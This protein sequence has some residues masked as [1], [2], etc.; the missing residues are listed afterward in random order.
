VLSRRDDSDDPDG[1][2]DTTADRGLP[3]GVGHWLY[4]DD[5]DNDGDLDLLDLQTGEWYVNQG[6][7]RFAQGANCIYQQTMPKRWDPDCEVILVDLDN[8][9][10]RDLVMAADHNSTR[11]AFLNLGDG[12]YQEI[13]S[14]YGWNRRQRK[15]GDVDGDGDLDMLA[16]TMH[17]RIALYRNDT[18]EHGL[19]LKLVP[20][21]AAEAHL[22]CKVW[23]YEAG[24]MGDAG[25]LIHYRQCF[26]GQQLTRSTLL[27]GELHVGL[28]RTR[29]VDVRVRFPSGFVSEIK[30]A[31]AG[32]R[33][34]VKEQ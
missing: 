15:F 2:K 6:S 19:R 27:L 21:A 10:Y 7:G 1:W 3:G 14:L 22:G 17:T 23:V 16:S 13:K 31:Q 33:T 5:W 24:K 25:S 8:N 28:G 18:T 29:T 4:P 32:S 20:K 9:G 11:G 12:D 30:N 26:H 34:I